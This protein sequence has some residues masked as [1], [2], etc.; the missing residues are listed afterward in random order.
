MTEE[1]SFLGEINVESITLVSSVGSKIDLKA[2]AAELCIYEDIFSNTMSGHVMIE[3]A[4]DLLNSMPLTGEELLEIEVWT[5]TLTNKIKKVF[6]VYKLQNRTSKKRVQTYMLNFC[7]PELIYSS[8]GKVAKAFSGPISR[9][10]ID[11]MNNPRYIVTDRETTNF[12]CEET[13]N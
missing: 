3:D 11:I 13:K 4:N 12:I 2:I 6:Y 8:L 5:P 1:I 7:S 9:T 10:V